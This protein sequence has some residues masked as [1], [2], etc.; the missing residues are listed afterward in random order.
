MLAYGVSSDLIDEFVW[1]EEITALESLKKF[2]TAVIDVFSEEYLRNPNNEDIWATFVKTIPSPQGHKRKL[3]AIAQEACRK[4]VECAFGVIQA[5]FAIVHG[6]ARFFHLETLQKIIKA[7]IILHN[8][9]V[10]DEWDD[11]EVVD[12]DY[13]QIDR[14]DNPSMQVLHEQSDGFMS[15]IKRNGRIRDREIHFQLQ[16]DLIEHLWQLQGES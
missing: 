5:R 1:I 16:L 10:E 13:E 9:I 4:D 11:N 6:L 7:Y 12:L 14:V 8:M 15:Y 2:V 3:F